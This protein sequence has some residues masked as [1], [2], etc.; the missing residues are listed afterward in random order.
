MWAA[1]SV[2]DSGAI[3]LGAS[4]LVMSWVILMGLGRAI[5]LVIVLVVGW[6]GYKLVCT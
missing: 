6:L 2:C 3:P 5:G 4:W 1:I